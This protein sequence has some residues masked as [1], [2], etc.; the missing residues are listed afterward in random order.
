MWLVKW[1]FVVLAILLFARL[2][3]VIY[4]FW[5]SVLRIVHLLF[6]PWVWTLVFILAIG[7]YVFVQLGAAVWLWDLLANVASAPV[8]RKSFTE[9]DHRTPCPS[10][11]AI[12]LSAQTVHRTSQSRQRSRELIDTRTAPLVESYVVPM[13]EED[14]EDVVAGLALERGLSGPSMFDEEV[15]LDR[16]RSTH[17]EAQ[18]VRT[19]AQPV[20]T[21]ARSRSFDKPEAGI[22]RTREAYV[23]LVG[24]R[25]VLL[26]DGSR[27]INLHTY[28]VEKPDIDFTAVLGRPEVRA[29]LRSAAAHPD[30]PKLRRKAERAL[31]AGRWHS[32]APHAIDF[33]KPERDK[34]RRVRM[35][36]AGAM[37]GMKGGA[38]VIGCQGVQLGDHTRQINHFTY[39]PRRATVNADAVLERSKAAARALA[40]VVLDGVSRKREKI[41]YRAV[42]EVLER[43]DVARHVGQ[44]HLGEQ[45]GNVVRDRDGVALGAG[46]IEKHDTKV[47]VDKSRCEIPALDLVARSPRPEREVKLPGIEGPGLPF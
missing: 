37:R 13:R 34:S 21:R 3:H 16:T 46:S 11:P 23:V 41:I 35:P 10:V 39:I 45:I 29:A 19:E 40:D 30:D 7:Y 4:G 24:C 2:V 28:R 8:R 6:N 1:F 18:P 31:R 17:G 5:V 38:I 12:A 43:R 27:Q 42:A 47:I 14:A 36:S 25:G 22:T 15:Q 9:A 33:G 20:R 44:Y 26:G 32:A